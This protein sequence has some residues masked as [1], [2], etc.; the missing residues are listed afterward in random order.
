MRTACVSVSV[1]V[2]GRIRHPFAVPD[3]EEPSQKIEFV[4][5]ASPETNR[6][7]PRELPPSL[8]P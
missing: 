7:K 8:N 1:P 3:S 2:L 4:F 6:G 5:S